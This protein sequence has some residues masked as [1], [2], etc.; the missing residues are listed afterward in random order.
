M[1]FNFLIS[2]GVVLMGLFASPKTVNAQSTAFTYQGRLNDNG[3]P[4][5][6]SYDLRF[7][8]YTS[9]TLGLASVGVTTNS[10]VAVTNGLF[11]TVVD[12]GPGVFAGG[13][14]WLEIA[15]STNGGSAFSTLSP[16]QIILPV[17]Y[18]SY[19]ATASSAI[20]AVSASRANSVSVTNISGILSTIQ[21]PGNLVT[22]GGAFTGKINATGGNVIT[23]L[24]DVYLFTNATAFMNGQ[25]Y[26]FTNS[27]TC[28]LQEVLDILN[29]GTPATSQFPH[30]GT[31]HFGPGIFRLKS[32][33]TI[34]TV[35]TSIGFEGSGVTACGILYEGTDPNT[36][37]INFLHADG[38]YVNFS[39]AHM[40][41]GG[42]TDAKCY[43]LFVRVFGKLDIRD[44]WF[45]YWPMMISGGPRFDQGLQPPS[46]G[47]TAAA[48]LCGVLLEGGSVD[49]IAVLEDCDFL[50]LKMGLVDASDHSV[51]SDNMFLFCGAN[52]G[53]T[54]WSPN[55]QTDW[56][57]GLQSCLNFIGGSI[58]IGHSTH[59]NH[60]FYNNYF[61]GGY[62]SYLCD[63]GLG[64]SSRMVSIGDG[65]ESMQY[66]VVLSALT[67]FT[68]INPHG[69]IPS[70]LSINALYYWGFLNSGPYVVSSAPPLNLLTE[71][72]SDENASFAGY[73]S[74]S[75]GDAI[76]S[77]NGS[78]LTSLNASKLTGTIPAKQLPTTVLTNSASGV[79][80]TGTFKGNGGALTNVNAD[81]LEGFHAAAFA[82]K[83]HVHSAADITSGTLADGRLS[84][85]VTLLNAY[86]TF[87]GANI[88]TGAVTATNT[89]NIFSGSLNGNA[90]TA[91][92]AT[93]AGNF[94]GPLAGDVT[95][96]QPATVVSTVAGQTAASVASGTIAANSATS[97]N[98]PNTLI[99]R[100]AS[101]NFA[102][103]MVV[104]TSGGFKFPDDTLQTSAAFNWQVI[105]NSTQA[106]PNHGYIIATPAQLTLTLPVT[107]V[108]GDVIRVAGLGLGGWRLAQASGQSVLAGKA[109]ALSA[110]SNW[111][112]H[113]SSH[114]WW[115]I[116]SSA[117]GTKLATM[118]SG[119]SIFTSTD[120]GSVW[121]SQ[122]SGIHSWR[123]I[124][125]SA[126]GGKLVATVAGG[127]IW[128][129]T[130]SGNSWV[131]HATTTNRNWLGSASAADGSKLAAVV[132]GGQI[133]ISLD[134]G[135]HWTAR[136][137]NRSWS[138]IACSSDGTK[139]VAAV[140]NGQLYTSTNSGT[141]WTATESNRAWTTVASS[142]DGTK[143]VA[144][145]SNGQIYTSTDSGDTWTAQESNR[146]W[147]SVAS[148]AD[149]NRLAAL[150]NNS[151]IYVSNDA[152][153]TWAARENNRA[154]Q[155]IASSSDGSKLVA[156]E[157][158]GLIYTS[159][160]LDTTTTASTTTGAAGYL[161]GGWGS[162]I[163]LVYV[164][165]GQWLPL[166]HEGT[167]F[168]Y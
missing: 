19:A 97:T 15:V 76:L 21:L 58:S 55:V 1:R 159:S 104:S 141:N 47:G 62:T 142:S 41:L 145:V 73:S 65:F 91:S 16:R 29:D 123:S 132:N 71:T 33:V 143:L 6:G 20:T 12:F 95:G 136:S 111:T 96:T 130:D 150:A 109:I 24:T 46:Y 83:N 43:L 59:M 7:T 28:G 39:M 66:N 114:N 35:N 10:A 165:N 31:V 106:V 40:F 167:I 138:A 74:V 26:R 72:L 79:S 93:S 99:K 108:A 22:N 44:C 11:T 13:S 137:T 166:T 61:Y 75:F 127:S 168:G 124:A 100:D 120:A 125:S 42:S 101:G 153:L 89:N 51:I 102:A 140:N 146:A 18:A 69:D 34:T 64:S 68:Q 81:L 45:G 133:W 126:D 90:A 116:A 164:G 162:T 161:T 48:N 84:A 77:G 105:S 110:D 5:T 4:V 158:G 131:S 30:G 115:A 37:A 54:E 23:N 80:L 87:T 78:G 32:S 8:L 63:D 82:L 147:T 50:G 94:S 157:N 135:A 155:S 118:N 17:P 139:L 86:Q 52:T 117:D 92:S 144:A 112:A 60:R 56:S 25:W 53:A 149:G 154:W 27:T 85:N 152:G 134:S 128:T 113:A 9:N 36:N 122:P 2:L 38:S 163:E 70:S 151:Q 121:T 3:S 103:A 119:G 148:S 98:S 14:N 67:G 129:S 156:V 88:F 57:I 160:P 107:P 49:N